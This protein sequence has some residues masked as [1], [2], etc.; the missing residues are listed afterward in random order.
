MRPELCPSLFNHGPMR[1]KYY[2]YL[3]DRLTALTLEKR[4]DFL[5]KIIVLTQHHPLRVFDIAR[6]APNK[7]AAE[8]HHFR[9][10]ELV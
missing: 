8:A 6:T 1:C 10:F 5:M 2:R 9:K 4:L 7:I 3:R